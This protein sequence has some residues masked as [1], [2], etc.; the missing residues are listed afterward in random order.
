[1]RTNNTAGIGAWRKLWHGAGANN[2]DSVF[3]SG[4][5]DSSASTNPN[6]NWL[7]LINS[8]HNNNNTGNQYQFQIAASFTNSAGG[9]WGAE[10]YWMRTNNTA[11]IGAWRKLWHDG[12]LVGDQ[13][14]THTHSQYQ[15]ASGMSAYQTVAGMS[16]YLTITN[17]ASTY[18]TQSA[19]SAYSTKTIADTLY[20]PIAL[21]TSKLD[22]LPTN[23]TG[24]DANTIVLNGVYGGYNVTNAQGATWCIIRVYRMPN[25]SGDQ[26]WQTLTLSYGGNRS[27]TRYATFDGSS[28][29]WSAWDVN[30]KGSDIA[31]YSTTAQ[32]NA[33]YLPINNPTFTG[34]LN[35]PTISGIDYLRVVKAG[36]NTVGTGP[37]FGAF[38]DTSTY[39]GGF[40]QLDASSGLSLYIGNSG[41]TAWV[42]AVKFY[43]DLS[44]NFAGSISEG[45][46]ALSTKYQAKFTGNTS[47]YV[48]GDG[49][50]A[51]FPT[52]GSLAA[53]STVTWTS[54]IINI[55]TGL[56]QASQPIGFGNIR[57]GTTAINGW[58]GIEFSDYK[59]TKL[60][61][62]S[63]GATDANTAGIY[64]GS[65]TDAGWLFAF[66]RT[67]TLAKGYVPATRVSGTLSDSQI[68]SAS[69]WNAKL[70]ANQTITISGVVS[71]SGTTAITTTM[72]NGALTIAKTS[73][74]Q[75]ALD[76]KQAAGSYVIKTG[77][78]GLGDLSGS[79]FRATKAVGL[80]GVAY[81]N[82]GLYTERGVII[83]HIMQVL[84]FIIM[85]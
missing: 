81:S 67:S 39:K 29:V 55:P 1:M 68:A 59:N 41:A 83:V 16:S 75:A 80:D 2:I 33:L 45:G 64:D 63:T 25:D 73:G 46:T 22:R 47:Q 50:L 37:Y 4:F 82:A 28:Y 10:N 12:N 58:H 21:S 43:T 60:L 57:F 17:A 31:N 18:Q 24:L 20:A 34:T 61:V 85:E 30:V 35:G 78:S 77:D 70:S 26:V 44:V 74:L 11:G 65:A 71:G 9:T 3:D 7:H 52:L 84:A 40:F 76:G 42:N 72:A 13:G 15:L 6:G 38:W 14:T 66:D 19:M 23:I 53:K 56:A 32:A 62:N 5:Y 51:T 79:G 36:S 69:V 8:A 54:D 48:R 27:F 49:S